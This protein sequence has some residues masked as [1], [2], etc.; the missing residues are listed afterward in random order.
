MGSPERLNYQPV[1]NPP[2]ATGEDYPWIGTGLK[3]TGKQVKGKGQ[4]ESGA[5]SPTT[6]SNVIEGRREPT[7]K[8]SLQQRYGFAKDQIQKD[9]DDWFR[10]AENRLLTGHGKA[11]A[12]RRGFFFRVPQP[13]LQNTAMYF[14]NENH[15]ED[16]HDDGPARIWLGAAIDRQQ[17]DQ[18]RGLE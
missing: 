3:A 7:W 1:G 15:A 14:S 17:V 2:H 6:I 4:G 13:R 12:I 10:D 16:D 18:I 11:P 9:V 8:A 5:N